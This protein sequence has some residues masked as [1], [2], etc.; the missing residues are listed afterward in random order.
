MENPQNS[1]AEKGD[2]SR[3][4]GVEQPAVTR[5]SEGKDD[6]QKSALPLWVA[7]CLSIAAMIISSGSLYVS[8]RSW[9]FNMA[10]AQP[11]ARATQ[12]KAESVLPDRLKLILSV[13]N[14]GKTIA[15][16]TRAVLDILPLWEPTKFHPPGESIPGPSAIRIDNMGDIAPG[17]KVE[18]TAILD[19]MEFEEPPETRRFLVDVDT[20][21]T[22]PTTGR[23]ITEMACFE[24]TAKGKTLLTPVL[25]RCGTLADKA[26]YEVF[27]QEQGSNELKR[28]K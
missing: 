3:V 13:E 26:S 23:Q 28:G 18:A 22:D 14:P 11:I 25:R 10:S 17:D 7:P 27:E 5:S 6:P 8:Y 19:F 16:E 9:Q 24:G 21:F 12:M 4:A 20:T 15:R 2:S 1:P